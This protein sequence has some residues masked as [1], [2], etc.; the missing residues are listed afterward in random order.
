MI[1]FFFYD[2]FGNDWLDINVLDASMTLV[3]KLFKF[4]FSIF[5]KNKKY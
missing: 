4:F 2:H 3:N 1:D 5:M